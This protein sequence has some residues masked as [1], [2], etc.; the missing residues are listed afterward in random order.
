[1]RKLTPLTVAEFETQPFRIGG[2][3]KLDADPL[4]VFAELG[5]PSLFFPL[6]RRSV[7]KTGATSG[8]GAVREIDHRIFGRARERML[9]WEPGESIAFTMT[10]MTSPFVA[11]MGE[12]WTLRREDIYTHVEWD[13][14]G[15]LTALGRMAKPLL[16]RTLTVLFSRAVVNIGKRAGSYKGES[17]GKQVS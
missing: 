10:E 6:M 12:V 14:V 11:Q 15:T 1:M 7:W 5:D 9:V 13:V 4:A 16:R 3:A 17:R 8:V 2:T